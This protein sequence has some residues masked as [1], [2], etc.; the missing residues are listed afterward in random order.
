MQFH[1]FTAAANG[2]ANRI[3]TEIHVCQGFDPA[4]HKSPP[5]QIHPTKAL[6]DTG[7]TN[8]VIT[9]A[10][11]NIL[12]LTPVGIVNVHYGS[13]P[14]KA[15]T[16]VVNLYLPNKVQIPGILVSECE[17]ANDFG[18]IIGMDIITQG[19]FSITNV[20]EKTITSFRVPSIET[21]DYVKTAKTLTFAGVGRND[22]CPCGKKDSAGKPLKFKNCCRP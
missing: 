4:A 14:T 19:D 18:V 17:D 8:S 3:I 11:A 22:P 6:W 16:H 21:I 10:T 12:K 2:R 15:N 20:D 5:Y 1:A 13:G 9:K 7:A